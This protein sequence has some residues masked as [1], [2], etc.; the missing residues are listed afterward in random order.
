MSFSSSPQPHNNEIDKRRMTGVVNGSNFSW[1]GSRKNP[2][3]SPPFARSDFY[4]SI[5]LSLCSESDGVLTEANP[6]QSFSSSVV[7]TEK[8]EKEDDGGYNDDAI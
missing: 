4:L 1:V 3:D 6:R 7:E 2:D 5:T 8:T